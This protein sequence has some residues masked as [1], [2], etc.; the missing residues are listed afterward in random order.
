[1]LIRDCTTFGW[2]HFATKSNAHSGKCI[3]TEY[4]RYYAMFKLIYGNKDAVGAMH[5]MNW[6]INRI[7]N[8]NLIANAIAMCASVF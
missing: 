4:V 2:A 7:R 1:M 6:V 5:K 8:Y 3:C